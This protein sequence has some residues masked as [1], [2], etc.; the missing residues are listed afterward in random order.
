LIATLEATNLAALRKTCAEAKTTA[1]QHFSKLVSTFTLP[2]APSF[3]KSECD[4]GVDS[5]MNEFN[6]ITAAFIE[7]DAQKEI[8]K[9]LEVWK[10][11]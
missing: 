5:A 2:V 8:K 1:V 9:E 11:T 10:E 3:V 4:I 6:T 7:T